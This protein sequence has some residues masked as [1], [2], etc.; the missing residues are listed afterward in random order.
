MAPGSLEWS[1]CPGRDRRAHG[2]GQKGGDSTDNLREKPTRLHRALKCDLLPPVK[3]DEC[4]R[5][6]GATYLGVGWVC[7]DERGTVL[8]RSEGP[9]SL[10]PVGSPERENPDRYLGAAIMAG[11]GSTTQLHLSSCA[12]RT[13]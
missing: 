9:R 3:N 2:A 6:T 8:V 10:L 11:F 1:S 12:T 7:A 5:Q 13:T 4:W